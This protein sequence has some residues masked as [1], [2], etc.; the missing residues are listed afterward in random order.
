MAFSTVYCNVNKYQAN[1]NTRKKGSCE[2]SS[3]RVICMISEKQF[4]AHWS[5]QFREYLRKK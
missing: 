1:T 2:E 4:A 3:A 5:K